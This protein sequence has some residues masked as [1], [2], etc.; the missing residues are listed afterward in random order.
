MSFS[1]N[2]KLYFMEK[3]EKEASISSICAQYGV[4][5]QTVSN[6]K[7]KKDA[8]RSFILIQRLFYFIGNFTNLNNLEL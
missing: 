7:M 4:A 2:D 3:L 6:I 1:F 8:I 5:K